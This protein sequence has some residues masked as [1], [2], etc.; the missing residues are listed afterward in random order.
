VIDNHLFI[1]PAIFAD[2]KN[3]MNFLSVLAIQQFLIMRIMPTFMVPERLPVG[4]QA[5]KPHTP[6]TNIDF[7][8][9]F[10]VMAMF[11]CMGWNDRAKL[12][13]AGRLPALPDGRQASAGAT[14]GLS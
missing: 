2:R 9:D 11:F 10:R 5:L 7:T 14:A 4:R 6:F 12:T 13:P 1:P 3:K 8:A